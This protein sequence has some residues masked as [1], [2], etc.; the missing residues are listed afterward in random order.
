MEN[1]SITE[2]RQRLGAT[3]LNGAYLTSSA[4]PADGTKRREPLQFS[5]QSAHPRSVLWNFRKRLPLRLLSR[6]SAAMHAHARTASKLGSAV[7]RACD[8]IKVRDL[9]VPRSDVTVSARQVSLSA[10]GFARYARWIQALKRYRS[11]SWV[12]SPRCIFIHV[13]N[14]QLWRHSE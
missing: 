13:V 3:H 6:F 8:V 11:S 4:S 5:D 9:L 10:A 1:P 12:R 7:A 2:L 14:F